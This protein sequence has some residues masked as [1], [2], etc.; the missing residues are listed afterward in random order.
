MITSAS[1]PSALPSTLDALDAIFGHVALRA[2]N[3]GVFALCYQDGQLVS[4]VRLD[5]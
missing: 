4:R 2:D 3:D 1:S 5:G